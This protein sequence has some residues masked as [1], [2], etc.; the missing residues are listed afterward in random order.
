MPKYEIIKEVRSNGEI[1][2]YVK[3]QGYFLSNSNMFLGYYGFDEQ[4]CIDFCKKAIEKHKLQITE[5]SETI[6]YSED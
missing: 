2:F 4:Q 1:W 3:H 5:P 6:V